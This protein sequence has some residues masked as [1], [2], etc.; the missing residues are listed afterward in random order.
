MRLQSLLILI[1]ASFL[2]KAQD[3]PTITPQFFSANEEI[4][5]SY[6]VTGTN[7]QSLSEAYIWMWLP[8]ES[9]DAPS[10]V[11]PAASDAAT[12]SPAKFTK[13]NEQGQTIFRITLTPITFFNQPAE[14]IG[15]I[16]MILKGNDWSDGQTGDFITEVTSGFAISLISPVGNYGFYD[17]GESIDI[18]FATSANSTISFSVDGVLETSVD[19]ATSFAT[20]HNVIADGQTHLLSVTADNGTE[21]LTKNYSYTTTPVVISASLPANAID[22]INYNT[23]TS[24]TLVLV[25]PQKNN[26][27]VIGDFNNWTLDNDYLMN[28]D[29]DKFWLT[30]N[31]LEAG[32]EYQFQYLVDGVIKIA[33]PYTT[34]IGSEFDD[35]EIIAEN[36]YPDLKLYPKTQTSE[37]VSFLQTNKP[38]F[39]WT[40]ESFNKPEKE[41]LVIYELL[42]RDFTEMR[43][44]EAVQDRLDYL[45]E[46]GINAIELMPVMEFEGNLSWGYNPFS[47]LAFDKYYGTETDFKTFV[48]ECHNRGIA[49]ILDIALNH[50]FGRNSLA[51][52]YNE[53]LYG[54]PTSQNPWFN[55]SARHDFNVG[56]DMNH[57]SQ[58]TQNYVDRVVSFWIEEYHVDGYRYDLS[59][60]FTQRNT[61]GNVG[62]WGQYDASRVAL[63]KR[64]ADHQWSVDEDSYVI[65]EHFADNAEEKELANYG[66]MLWGNHNDD[67]KNLAKGSNRN[68][69]NM[70]YESRGYK[71]PYL[72]NYMESHDEERVAFELG[73]SSTDALA[74]QMQRLKLNAA[75]FFMVPGPKMLWQFGEFGYDLELNDDRLG[76]KPTKW[77]YLDNDARQSLFQVYQSLIKLKTRTDFLNK[78]NFGWSAGSAVKWLRYDDQDTEFVLAGNFSKERQSLDQQII[79]AGTWYD[80]FTGSELVIETSDEFNF[81]LTAGEFRLLVNKPIDNY[82]DD[83]IQNNIVLANKSE[84]ILSADVAVFPNP[85]NG[86]FQINTTDKIESVKVFDVMGKLQTH[87]LNVSSSTN[88]SLDISHLPQ[89]IYIIEMNTGHSL[90]SKRI[91]LQD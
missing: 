13:L 6:N 81:P 39:N 7:L 9:I 61:L 64:L 22:G 88:L 74:V 84:T 43:T 27:F 54:N 5:I 14:K 8:D 57:E 36:R 2:T 11:N 47:M 16:G 26:V 29:G 56:Y 63:L 50:Q 1:F 62:L 49:V 75:F 91:I 23:A 87:Q 33:D 85:S 78:D 34:K 10:N 40:D 30:I 3:V 41:D 51:R 12:T 44:V 65:L 28:K 67:F 68:I 45:E 4:T 79:S 18:N 89:G 42:I 17:S 70:F 48:N 24:T 72:I 25:A 15:K 32:K 52:L 60:G 71:N 77:E 90:V 86:Q 58:L 76:I 31:N 46:L 20:T 80:Y 19:N 59:K 53:D 21:Q 55:T 69:S 38:Q 35:N 73:R 66:M 83:A 37:A 82:I